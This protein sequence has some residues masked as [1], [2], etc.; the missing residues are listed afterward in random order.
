MHRLMSRIPLF[1]F[2]LCLTNAAVDYYKESDG[3]D[4]VPEHSNEWVVRIDEGDEVADLVAN[5]LGLENRRKIFDNYYLFI[6]PSVPR[7]SKRATNDF[8]NLLT[9]H[10]KVSWA[11]QQ[12]SRNRVKRDFID[13]RAQEERVYRSVAFSDPKWS[14]EWYLKD[15]RPESSSHL[16]K[17]DLHVLPAWAAGYTGKG[18]K[19]TILDDGLEWNNSDIMANYDPKA[20]YDLN[21]NDDDPSPRYDPTN[22]NKHGTRCAGEVA[23]VANNSICGVGIAYNAK[24]GGIRM[25]DGHVTDRVEAEAIAF[26]HKYVDIYSASWGPNDDGRTVEGPGTLASAAFIKGIT[27]GR[28]GKGVIYVWASGNGG[29]RQDNCNCD[30]YTG[31]IYTISISSASEHQQSPWY[32]ERCPSTMATTYSSGAYKD[33][34][35]TTTDLHDS[36]TD[37]HT[38][39][40]ASA[41]LAAGI[42]ALVLE[43]NPQLTWRDMQHLVAWTSEYAPLADNHGWTTNGA[44]FKVNSRFGFG[45]LNAAALTEAARN[46]VTVPKQSICQIEPTKFTPQRISAARPLEIDF[47]VKGCEGE[48][49]VVRFLEHV[50]LYVT[51]S[52]TR[53]GA[54]KINITSPHGTRTTLLSERDQDTSTDGFKNWSFMSV[55]NWGENPKGVWTIKIMDATGDMENLGALEDFR[56]VLHGTS[57]AP[58]RMLAGPRVYDENYNTVQNERSEKRQSLESLARQQAMV[59]SNKLASKHDAY[60]QQ[61]SLDEMNNIPATDSHWF[62]LLARLNG[63]WLQ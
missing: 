34:K 50:Q 24:I 15:T 8:T 9:K 6:N 10:E 22:E 2:L 54:L 62:R 52:Y 23:M 44:G 28:N 63:N 53:R 60:G 4:F 39:T 61:D 5:E 27:E 7:R 3:I 45:L 18:I 43:A 29:R 38:G 33:Q 58:H 57:E 49:N 13:K 26:N 11:E 36:C 12:Q 56:L 35:V 55:H 48:N 31:S 37:D 42:F 21:D 14:K 17:L 47:E 19:V 1:F 30:G 41:P 32:A 46:W 16:P 40:S 25:L 59:E 51:I 20:S